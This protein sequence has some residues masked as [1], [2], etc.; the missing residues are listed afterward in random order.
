MVVELE[1]LKGVDFIAE[2]KAARREVQRRRGS[3]AASLLYCL[4]GCD[5]AYGRG[6]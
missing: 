6:R 1:G 4:T 3:G 2:G 5:A